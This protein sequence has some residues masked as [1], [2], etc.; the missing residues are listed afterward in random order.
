M[1]YDRIDLDE[2]T[3]M[4]ELAIEECNDE[5]DELTLEQILDRVKLCRADKTNI[6]NIMGACC[7]PCAVHEVLCELGYVIENDCCDDY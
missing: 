7:F 4:I 5:G 3:E 6:I 2:L 1:T